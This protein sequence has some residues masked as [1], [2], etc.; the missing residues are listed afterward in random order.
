VDVWKENV[1][2]ELESG[3]MEYETAEEFL[4]TLKKEFGGGEEEAVKAAE[5]RKLEQGGRTMEEFIQEFKRAAR[6][7]GYEGR[8]LVEE[9]KRGMNG[10]IRRKLMEVE[11]PLASIEQWYRRAMALDRN[12][13]E[14]RREEER[15]RGKKE[16]MGSAPKQEQ[17]QNLPRPLVWQRRQMPQQAT[18]GPALMEGVERT[19]VVVVRGQGQSAGIPPRQDPFAMEVDRGRNCF[20]CG[21]FGHMARHCRNHGRGGRVAENRR[22]E[23]GGGQIEEI[24]NFSNNLKAGENLELLN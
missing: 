12:W 3:E 22:V 5:L 16:V 23:Y 15:L 19:N 14:S 21:D 1:L 24:M 8:P 11:N 10:G 13:R 2:E 4:T 20:A 9:F 18:I 17:R 6:G 7:S